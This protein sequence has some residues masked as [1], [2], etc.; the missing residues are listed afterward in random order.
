MKKSVLNVLMML[1]ICFIP[2]C[3]YA[4]IDPDPDYVLHL[5]VTNVTNDILSFDHVEIIRPFSEYKVS[6][7]VIHPGENTMITVTKDPSKRNDI[8]GRVVF[9]DS[10]GYRVPLFIQDQVQ[11]HFGQ[12]IFSV[13]EG[14]QYHSEVVP[15]SLVLNENRG[16]LYLNY[17]AAHVRIFEKSVS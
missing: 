12:P 1:L 2:V 10:K 8:L 13:F 11:F 9:V 16:V 14:G 5:T 6:P 17:L 15:K 4:Y 7:L 3:S